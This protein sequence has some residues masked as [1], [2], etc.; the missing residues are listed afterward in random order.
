MKK[1]KG[2]AIDQFSINQNVLL[3]STE[4]IFKNLLGNVK[5]KKRISL[6]IMLK[7]SELINQWTNITKKN[8]SEK[9]RAIIL[10]HENR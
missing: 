10:F 1:F 8:I 2:F 6:V 5:I 9:L 7:I 3:I 4:T